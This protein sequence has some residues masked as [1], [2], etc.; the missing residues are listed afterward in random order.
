L[1]DQDHPAAASTVADQIRPVIGSAAPQPKLP[2]GVGSIIGQSFSIL[3]RNFFRVLIIG[4]VPSFFGYLIPIVILAVA[5]LGTPD[6]LEQLQQ[7]PANAAA[8][9]AVA[10]VVVGLFQIAVFA[11]I[12][13]LL[14]QLAYDAKLSRPVKLRRYLKPA[15]SA[16]PSIVILSIV[17]FIILLA[18]TFP[19]VLLSA[20]LGPLSIVVIL[21]MPV[22]NLWIFAVF[23]VMAPAI[24]IEHIGFRGLGRSAA[25]TK[26]YRW[27]IVGTLLL[28]AIC[29][30]G[31]NIIIGA[32]FMLLVGSIAFLGDAGGIVSVIAG[33]ILPLILYAVISTIGIGLIG[34][35]IALIYARL[36]EIKEG[37]S[38]DQIASVFE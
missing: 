34:I 20:L 36:R 27:P 19:I 21:G 28:T 10:G 14:A 33:G 32:V 16:V 5:G 23:A 9:I 7:Q 4:F 6:S 2:L 37:I 15:L 1:T 13:A 35:I 8:G 12:A 11:F 31:L 18:I 22:L 17:V 25:L 29:Y 30:L 38:V 24:V 26:Q 3:F